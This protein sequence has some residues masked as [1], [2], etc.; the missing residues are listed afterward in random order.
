MKYRLTTLLFGR[1]L[2]DGR[3]L[4]PSRTLT[5]DALDAPLRLNVRAP[6]FNVSG[7]RA[8]VRFYASLEENACLAVREVGPLQCARG[9]MQSY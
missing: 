3:F 9:Q 4:L 1:T 2:A 7:D 8:D 6:I 5:K